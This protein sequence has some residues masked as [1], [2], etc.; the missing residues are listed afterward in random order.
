MMTDDRNISGPSNE[1]NFDNDTIQKL[2]WL[3]DTGDQQALAVLI[4][5]VD[6]DVIVNRLPA[7]REDRRVLVWQ[8]LPEQRREILRQQMQ[9]EVYE[10]L[11]QAPGIMTQGEILNRVLELLQA[12]NE[13]NLH[14]MLATF[15]SDDT[16]DIVSAMP[17]TDRTHLWELIPEYQQGE[18]LSLLNDSIR[19]TLLRTLDQDEVVAA[20]ADLD[21]DDLVD[22]VASASDE[23]ADAI[24]QSL[25][26]ID[27]ELIKARLEYQEDSAGRLMETDWIAVRADVSLGVVARYLKRRGDLPAH[28]DGLMV[29]DREGRY[30]GKLPVSSLLILKDELVVDNV[31]VENADWLSVDARKEEIADLFE[32]REVSSI[33]VVDSEHRLVGRITLDEA[34]SL[35]REKAELPLMHMAGLKEDEDLFAP[36]TSSAIRRM[37]WLGI[38]LVTAFIAAW[39]IGLFEATLQEIV[40]LAVLM[41]IVASMGGIAGSQTLTLAIR[42]LALG[43]ISHSNTRW[44]AMKEVAIAAINGLLW[45]TVVGV[46][47]YAWF[48]E[49]G[50]SVIIGIAMV[51]NQFAAA[52]SGIAIPLI[53]DRYD[54]DPALSGSV[55]LTT[56]TDVVGFMS[57]LGLAT[58][59]LL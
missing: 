23:L 5:V 27:R 2:E 3:A 15:S 40:A 1:Q 45:A 44:L 47:A 43:Q 54:I 26:L 35:I 56:V 22:V 25:D 33:A 32:R 10:M 21:H 7:M 13:D 16:A 36:I 52:V 9:P 29:V 53:L 42:G 39:V 46:I 20:T 17:L 49:I 37:L 18:V 59:L 24:F 58:L 19:Q 14:Q 55:V 50:I 34:L 28:S 4:E 57:F 31:M 12:G 41:P 51:I 48:G 38:N 6:D 11:D 30:L 8:S